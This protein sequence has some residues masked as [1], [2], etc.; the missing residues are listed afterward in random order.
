MK[1]IDLLKISIGNL[2]R[3][4]L[5]TLLTIL[6]VIIGTTSVVT[7]ISLGI[8]L[9]DLQT[10]ALKEAGSLTAIDVS[11][12][13]KS[14]DSLSIQKNSKV[15]KDETIKKFSALDH[16]RGVSPLL[17][18]NV[19]LIQGNWIANT[20]ITG[21]NKYYMESMKIGEGK[22][23]DENSKEL[24]Y[25][26]GN[27]VITEFINSKNNK[28]YY[29]T[30]K[31]PDVDLINRPI[32]TIFDVD[33]YYASKNTGSSNEDVSSMDASNKE[34]VRI[35]KKYLIKTSGVIAGGLDDFN[36]YSYGIYADI[37]ALKLELN[38][39]FKNKPIPGQPTTKKGKPYKYY[40]YRRA[41]VYVD[42][43]K[44]VT[45]VQKQIKD[46]GFQAESNIEW[47]EQSKKQSNMIQAFLGGI[48]AIS[49]FVAAIGIANTMMMSIYERTKEIGIMKVLGCDMNKIR[50]MFLIES[51]MIGFFGGLTGL[52]LS[53]IISIIINKFGT[54]ALNFSE[55]SGNLSQIPYYLALFSIIFSTIIGMLAGLFPAI[56]AMKL[57]PL[58]ALRNE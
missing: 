42:D 17:D 44:N 35:P 57:S 28:G 24:K 53:Y 3:R 56:R 9:D 13:Y 4:K 30:M 38:K 23:I 10:K 37:E 18:I 15:I 16:V 29:D 7:M 50:D 27:N 12:D 20:S 31:L 19:I 43:M 41:I 45:T 2:N 1:L 55:F 46:M 39:I 11:S 54:A 33:A 26:F 58:A 34:P 32:F 52:L 22:L 5:R 6:G 25:I 21:V 8:G 47:L 36:Q 14:M 51:G 48:G 49:L 40:I